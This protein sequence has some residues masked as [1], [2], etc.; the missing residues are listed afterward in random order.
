MSQKRDDFRVHFPL[1]YRAYLCFN[2]EKW[3][4][5]N[6]SAGGVKAVFSGS[7]S[8]PPKPGTTIAAQ[9]Q[10]PPVGSCE[11]EGTILRVE[12]QAG[13][14]IMSFSEGKGISAQDMMAIHRHLIQLN[15]SQPA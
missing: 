1:F 11:V 8:A 9:V 10:M 15:G 2:G 12:E 13:T 7:R 3:R 14:V 5:S 4:I 6:I